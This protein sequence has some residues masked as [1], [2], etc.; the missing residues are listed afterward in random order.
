MSIDRESYFRSCISAI[1]P[2]DFTKLDI[3]SS[4]DYRQLRRYNSPEY[5]IV[6][7]I[8]HRIK[9]DAILDEIHQKCS[10]D[11]LALDER[12]Q[13]YQLADEVSDV[14]MMKATEIA[15]SKC[16]IRQSYKPVLWNPSL[17]NN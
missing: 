16:L 6:M 13:W 2:R 9:N 14:I 17:W 11:T 8:Y 10:D 15:K 3:S 1:I 5:S 7:T 4:E 12:E